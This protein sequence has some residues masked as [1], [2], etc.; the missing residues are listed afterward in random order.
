MATV[1]YVRVSSVGQN[2]ARQLDGITLDKVFTDKCSG[3]DM[4][5]PQLERA[6]EF[7][8]EGDELVVHSMDRLARN[9]DDLRRIVRDL[10]ARG[11]RVRFVKEGQ[12]FTG[13]DSHISKLLLSLLGAVAEF[14]RDLIKERQ[15][16]GIAIA[17]KAGT[18]KGRKHSLTPEKADELRKRVEAGKVNKADLAREFGISR[19][20]LYVYLKPAA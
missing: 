4:K 1:G 8:R 19:A 10:T 7:L 3:K 20:A 2:D 14:E 12:T 9:L 16:E 11:V 13:E 6:L 17:K 5:R 18:Y 15:L